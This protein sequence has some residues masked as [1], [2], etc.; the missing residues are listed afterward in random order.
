MAYGGDD[1]IVFQSGLSGTINAEHQRRS[2]IY[3]D[4]LE[5]Q[6]PGADQITVDGDGNDRIFYS[7]ELQRPR[8]PGDDLG[9]DG[10]RR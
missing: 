9:A 1:T 2:T 4:E 5:I 3:D 6:G 7:L 10:D 8:H